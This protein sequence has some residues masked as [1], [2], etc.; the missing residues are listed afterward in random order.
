LKLHYDVNPSLNTVNAYGS[1]FGVHLVHDAAALPWA[2]AQVAALGQ[3]AVVEAYIAGR[4]LTVAAV[5]DDNGVQVLPVAEVFRPD[6]S[7]ELAAEG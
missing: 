6:A 2:L 3:A 5:V 4:E 1:G 7:D